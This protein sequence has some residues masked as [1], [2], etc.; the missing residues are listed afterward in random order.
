MK[1]TPEVL[2]TLGDRFSHAVLVFVDEDGYP[3]AV[4]TDFETDPDRGVV[5][6]RAI[7]GEEVQPPPDEQ[8]NVVFSHIRPQPGIGYDERRY[9]PLDQRRDGGAEE[10]LVTGTL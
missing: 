5:K 4:A 7:A 10:N 8:V 6:L 1:P 3:L 9:V 2:A